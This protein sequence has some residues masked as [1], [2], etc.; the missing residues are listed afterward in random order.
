M[1][2]LTFLCKKRM[3]HVTICVPYIRLYGIDIHTHICY[4]RMYVHTYVSTG[5]QKI[6]VNACK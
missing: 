2:L 6:F 1:E 4:V 3:Q 5:E